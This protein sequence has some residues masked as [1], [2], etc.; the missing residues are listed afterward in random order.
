MTVRISTGPRHDSGILESTEPVYIDRRHIAD[1]R[2]RWQSDDSDIA[3][4]DILWK[5]GHRDHSLTYEEAIRRIRRTLATHME[6][7]R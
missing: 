3:D 5:D 2:V 1:I 7:A 4:Y 6:T